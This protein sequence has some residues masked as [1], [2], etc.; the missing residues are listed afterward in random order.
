MLFA[1]MGAARFFSGQRVVAHQ[2]AHLE[3]VSDATGLFELAVHLQS[4][5]DSEFT[6]ELIAKRS[7]LADGLLQSGTGTR[8]SALIVQ[9]LSEGFMK[10]IGRQLSLNTQQPVKLPEGSL[11]CTRKFRMIDIHWPTFEFIGQIVRNRRRSD[12]IAVDTGLEQRV[13][14]EPVCAVVREISFAHGY[15]PETVVMSS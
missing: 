5:W 1:E 8:Q 14:S 13:R 6:V 15:R 12:K 3:V 7:D 10:V 4:P 9:D 2:F 11:F